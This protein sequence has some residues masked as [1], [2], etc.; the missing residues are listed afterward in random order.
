[1]V[2]DEIADNALDQTGS[3]AMFD[4]IANELGNEGMNVFIISHKAN[5]E[6]NVRSILSLEKVNGFTKIV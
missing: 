2:L 5:L 6:E 3:L 1:L 4:I